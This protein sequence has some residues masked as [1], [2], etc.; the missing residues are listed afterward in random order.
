MK[1]TVEY[2]GEG[3]YVLMCDD[4]R[5]SPTPAGPRLFKAPPW[6]KI[7]FRHDELEPAEDAA[8]KLRVYLH[9]LSTRK[10]TKKQAREAAE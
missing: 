8:A 9:N 1:I 6:P 10:P 7:A 2:D 5:M 3:S 4:S